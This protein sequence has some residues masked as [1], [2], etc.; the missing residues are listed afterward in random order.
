VA[1]G[2][3]AVNSLAAKA[4]DAMRSIGSS[5][6][7]EG[8]PAATPG[9][10]VD[11]KVLTS[12]LSIGWYGPMR[13]APAVQAQEAEEEEDEDESQQTGRLAS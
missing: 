1:A 2:A 8:A 11:I 4:G 9:R 6:S 10:V 7:D 5:D 3:P 13:P 12:A